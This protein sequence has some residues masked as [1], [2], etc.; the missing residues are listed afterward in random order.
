MLGEHHDL[1][2]EFPQHRDTI[3]AL[4]MNN[5]HFARLFEEY[6]ALDKQV[7][8]FETG[9]ETVA[10]EHLD[11]L[12]RNRVTLKDELYAMIIAT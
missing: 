3:R 4:K 8:Q 9:L 11:Q 12:K 6:N 2:H 7:R 5:R 10:D 1:V